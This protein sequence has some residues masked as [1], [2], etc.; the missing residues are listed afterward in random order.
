MHFPNKINNGLV[1]LSLPVFMLFL[2]CTP[3][4]SPETKITPSAPTESPSSM[5]TGIFR[6]VNEHRQSMGLQPL[7]MNEEANRQAFMHSKNMATGKTAFS[8]D[9]FEQRIA[10]IKKTTGWITA[11]AE[12]VAYGKLTAREVVKGWLNS[13]GHKKNIEGNYQYTGIGIYKDKNGVTYFT[14]IFFRN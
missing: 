1:L 9:G 7:K 4:L 11:S 10:S 3:K 2:S 13:P 12:N 6:Y 14:Q 5:V 8:H